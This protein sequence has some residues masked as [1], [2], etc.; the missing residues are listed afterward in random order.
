MNKNKRLEELVKKYNDDS[1]TKEEYQEF[2][3]MLNDSNNLDILENIVTGSWHM[4]QNDQL[5]GHREGEYI[6]TKF[7]SHS[8]K[9]WNIAASIIILISAG[10]MYFILQSPREI[11]TYYKTDF[12][13]I[14]E[15]ELPDGSVVTLN[16]NSELAWDNRWKKN[17]NRQVKLCGEAFFDIKSLDNQMTFTVKTGDVSVEVLGTSFNVNSRDQKVEVY[18]DEGKVNLLM[19]NLAKDII[20]MEPGQKVKY[21]AELKKTEKTTNESMISSASWKKGVLNFKEMKFQEVLDKLKNIYGKSFKCED[22]DLLAK[23]IYLGV[24]YSDWES[25]RQA[26]ELSLDIQIKES[27]NITEITS[28]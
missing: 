16:A 1:L 15:V 21:D 7:R 9:K 28:N 6:K 14:L 5:N 8:L 24:P 22:L 23:T 11:N 4:P 19:D 27:G 3:L 25:L 17:G 20:V 13:Q 2:I 18:L 12:S 26:L 10:F